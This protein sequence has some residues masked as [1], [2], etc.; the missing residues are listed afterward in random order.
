MI[1]NLVLSLTT[2]ILPLAAVLLPASRT[3]AADATRADAWERE[4]AAGRR[5]WALQKPVAPAVPAVRDADWPR[6]A[7]DRFLL[8]AMERAGVRPVADAG[9]ESL[10]RR[11]AFDLVGLPPTPEE[12]RAFVAD[13]SPQAVERL[14]DRLLASPRFG[15][16]WARHWLDVARYADSSGKET[17]V[18]YPHAWRYRDWVIAAFNA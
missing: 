2:A 3:A 8:A 17:N 13:T 9:R 16:R 15:E 18:P 5:H 1:R 14:V 6:G 7:I 10:I 11:L 4:V 12:V